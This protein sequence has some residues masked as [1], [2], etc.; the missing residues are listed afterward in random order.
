MQS[1]KLHIYIP[2]YGILNISEVS[3]IIIITCQPVYLRNVI[4]I[5]STSEI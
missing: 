5:K 4:I 1:L 2:T 3:N